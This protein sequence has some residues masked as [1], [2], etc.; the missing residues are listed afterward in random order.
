MHTHS[1]NVVGIVEEKR[2]TVVGQGFL[3]QK[4]SKNTHISGAKGE[5][6]ANIW[7]SPRRIS[8][9]VEPIQEDTWISGERIVVCQSRIGEEESLRVK[10]KQVQCF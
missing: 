10:R 3:G 5:T 6:I 4:D 2:N 7:S 8:A 9:C 1:C